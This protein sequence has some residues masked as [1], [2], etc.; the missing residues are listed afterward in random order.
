MNVHL[1]QV[2]LKMNISKLLILKTLEDTACY[3]GLLLAPAEGFG[4]RRRLFLPFGQKMGFLCCFGPFLAIFGCPA[5]TMVTFSRNLSNFEKNQ[6]N[7]KIQKSPKNF[8]KFQ[9]E[10]KRKN[11]K[12]SKKNP[13]KRRTNFHKSIPDKKKLHL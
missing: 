3:V 4:L 1:S 9:K 8:K 12:K 2:L 10:K 13:K 5:V 11:L 7:E 6:K